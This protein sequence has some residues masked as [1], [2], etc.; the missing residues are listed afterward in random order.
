[1]YACMYACMY[2]CMYVMFACMHVHIHICICTQTDRQTHTHTHTHTHISTYICRRMTRVCGCNTL[3]CCWRRRT[4]YTN[5]LFP[6][7]TRPSGWGGLQGAGVYTGSRGRAAIRWGETPTQTH[8]H[9]RRCLAPRGGR[10]GR[11]WKGCPDMQ[12][13]RSRRWKRCGARCCV[14]VDSCEFIWIRMMCV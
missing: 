4:H 7:K 11:R 14:S 8:T 6:A 12:G 2:V 10:S 3:G 5:E 13:W 1:M 9:T